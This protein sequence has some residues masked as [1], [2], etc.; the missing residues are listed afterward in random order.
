MNKKIGKLYISSKKKKF[1]AFPEPAGSRAEGGGNLPEGIPG[2]RRRLRSAQIFLHF[3]CRFRRFPLFA[4]RLF[5]TA[6][7]R[8]Q[9][10]NTRNGKH[11]LIMRL[12]LKKEKKNGF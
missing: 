10:L 8:K 6:N 7:G 12:K 9:K 3:P 4:R 5:S 11:V 1:N 2:P